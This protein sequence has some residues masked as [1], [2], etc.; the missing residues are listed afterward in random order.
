MGEAENSPYYNQTV[1]TATRW[2][3]L[4]LKSRPYHNQS[5]K[6]QNRT[7][8]QPEHNI[9]RL[10]RNAP[11]PCNCQVFLKVFEWVVLEGSSNGALGVLL[12]KCSESAFGVF[13]ERCSESALGVLL[14]CFW[15]AL[16]KVL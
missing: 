5:Q 3:L 11:R 6:S 10:Q 4:Q 15:S 2:T 16:G 8:L 9:M 7:L 14:E 12:E 13:L 1:G